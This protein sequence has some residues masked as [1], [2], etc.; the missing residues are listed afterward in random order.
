MKNPIN[1]IG[2]GITVRIDNVGLSIPLGMGMAS[3]KKEKTNQ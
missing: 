1:M 3:I 2:V